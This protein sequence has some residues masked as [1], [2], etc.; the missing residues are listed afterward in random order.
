MKT[1]GRVK[2]HFDNVYE[3]MNRKVGPYIIYQIGD[4]YCEP[5]YR[6]PNHRQLV[7]E[8]SYIVS[9][10][11]VFITN[12]TE[13]EVSKGMLYL[14]RIGEDHEIRSSENEPLRYFYLGFVF[15]SKASL[16]E[17]LSKQ[18]ALFDDPKNRMAYDG[19]GIQDL[20]MKMFTELLTLDTFTEVMLEAYLTQILVKTYRAFS[21]KK[22][23][24]YKVN[25][26]DTDQNRVYDIVHYIDTQAENIQNLAQLSRIFGYSYTHIA[27]KFY[28]VT[29][30]HLRSYYFKR[31]FEK[32]KEYILKGHSITATAEMIGYKSIHAFSRA[33][34]GFVGMTPTDFRKWAEENMEKDA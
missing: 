22:Y 27:Q 26:R 10:S 15:D 4:L 9:G 12:G 31:R 28:T 25:E 18:K 16:N 19:T 1:G 32:A 24:T 29:G 33:F 11:G 8:I 34:H 23:R 3:E 14:N 30:E 6:V 7:H 13:T 20:F 21:Q 2:F 17:T 5:G